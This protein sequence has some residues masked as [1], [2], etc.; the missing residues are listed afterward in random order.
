MDKPDYYR[1]VEGEYVMINQ[2]GWAGLR[3][4]RIEITFERN[5]KNKCVTCDSIWVK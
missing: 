3:L 2:V 1:N 4:G 5:R